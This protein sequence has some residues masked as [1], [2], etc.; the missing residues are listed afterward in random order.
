S[1]KSPSNDKKG[2]CTG[3]KAGKTHPVSPRERAKHPEFQNKEDIIRQLFKLTD[4]ART[5]LKI[6]N[7]AESFGLMLV[8]LEVR[9]L[10]QEALI[11]DLK[12]SNKNLQ[13]TIHRLMLTQ[14]VTI[15]SMGNLAEYRDPETG[16]HIKRT[17][18]YVECMA[19]EIMKRGLYPDNPLTE[20]DIE[21]LTKSAPLHD[22]GKVGVPDSVLIK[23]GRLTD[24]EF[25]EMKKHTV[26]GRDII[27]SS[28]QTLGQDSFLAIA[29]E[30][31]SS[32]HEK[33]D[34]TGYPDGKKGNEIPLF[35]RIMAIADVYDALISKRVYKDAF[36][37]EKAVSIICEGRGTQFDPTLVD[38][39]VSI[40]DQFRKIALKYADLD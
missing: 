36:S 24:E 12:K 6:A 9:E 7:L 25:E 30:I 28:E 21:M 34:G 26:Y 8:K 38:L 11:Q 19:T 29:R 39:F 3:K 17:R 32:H 33:W 23:P 35:R 20:Q 27:A 13:E 16:G 37:H 40:D 5:S 18:G 4:P 1:S 2:S 31:A 22:I 14:D 15:N 10:K